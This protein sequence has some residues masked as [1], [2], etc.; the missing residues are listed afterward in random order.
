M[1]INQQT[2]YI[3]DGT[4]LPG[5]DIETIYWIA[6]GA[7][8][9]MAGGTYL[10]SRLSASEHRMDGSSRISHFDERGRFD[11]SKMEALLQEE[12]QNLEDKGETESERYQGVVS[13]LDVLS[14]ID[15]EHADFA[16]TDDLREVE[17]FCRFNKIYE[18]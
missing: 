8:V 3:A 7:A 16:K 5:M 13:S 12:R 4:K 11:Y 2:L 1:V 17:I 18:D 6:G 14:E 10:A 9:I 15:Y